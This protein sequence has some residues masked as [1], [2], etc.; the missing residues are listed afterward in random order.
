MSHHS[1]FQAATRAITAALTGS[2]EIVNKGYETSSQP[3]NDIPVV[4]PSTEKS[5]LTLEKET[6]YT[7]S[8]EAQE[9]KNERNVNG[10][11]DRAVETP[12]DNDTKVESDIAGDTL[13]V[14]DAN[15]S[16]TKMITR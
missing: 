12:E 1:N 2:D 15:E 8:K 14:N 13:N 9:S 16:D 4:H 5:E 6:K 7:D 11:I 10:N 3:S